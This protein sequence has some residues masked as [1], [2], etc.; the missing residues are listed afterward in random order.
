MNKRD[1]RKYGKLLEAERARLSAGIRKLEEETLYQPT[2][3]NTSDLSSLAEV[4]TDNFERETALNIACN[5]SEMLQEIADA[6][7]RIEQGTYGTCEGCEC[8]IPRQ[9]L[10]VFPSAR[11]CVGCKSRLEKEGFLR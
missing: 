4:G 11:H 1:A 6:L 5:E 10:Q 8:D 3:E 2:S 7:E 9:R